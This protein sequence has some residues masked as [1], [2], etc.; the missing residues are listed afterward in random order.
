MSKYKRGAGASFCDLFSSVPA[1]FLWL[2]RFVVRPCFLVSPE[3]TY[4]PPEVTDVP[5][6]VTDRLVLFFSESVLPWHL[7]YTARGRHSL[8]LVREILRFRH[9]RVD[10]L[11]GVALRCVFVTNFN[12]KRPRFS[13][14]LTVIGRTL[15]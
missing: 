1:R 5:P 8:D 9:L 14:T 15:T 11:Q 6:E 7:R 4:V 10:R 13:G 12:V 2:P 3:V